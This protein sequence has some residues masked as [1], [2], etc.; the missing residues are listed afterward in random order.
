MAPT[1]MM[2]TVYIAIFL[3]LL[4]FDL[5]IYV[6]ANESVKRGLD[7]AITSGITL[8]T[9]VGD[10]SAGNQRLV[11]GNLY[12]GVRSIFRENMKLDANMSSE[13]YQNGK[14]EVSLQYRSDGAPRVVAK[15]TCDVVMISGRFIGL[16][17]RPMSVTKI[18]PYNAEYK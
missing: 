11:E 14:L 4:S 15:F 16:E 9:D 17:S 3:I 1:K 10:Y 18:T 2:Y 12:D 5:G 6:K 8:G 13:I 7:K